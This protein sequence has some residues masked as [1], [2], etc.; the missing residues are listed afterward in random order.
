MKKIMVLALAVLFGTPPLHA[1]N[2]QL[3]ETQWKA[4]EG[5]YQ[6]GIN[7][8]YVR[9]TRLEG[10]KLELRFPATGKRLLL[11]P[12]SELVF[13]RAPSEGEG[14][15][16]INFHRD[17][18]TGEVTAAGVGNDMLWNRV[19][20]YHPIEPKE[21]AH[22][23]ED[24]KPFEGI[25]RRKFGPDHY[26]FIQLKEKANQLVFKQHWDGREFVFLP[27]SALHFF[28]HEAT[29]F[30]LRF[31]KSPDGQITEFVAFDRDHWSKQEL[32]VTAAGMRAYEGKYRS[33]SDP[34]NQ[35]QLIVRD[36]NLVVKQVWD[37]KEIVLTPMTDIYF[38]NETQSYPLQIRLGTDGKVSSI[39]VLSSQEF[40]KVPE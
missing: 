10:D 22:T 13:D 14:P 7:K 8:D 6:N 11:I 15:R 33:K 5:V 24:L 9:F 32:S 16:Q 29:R 35:L 4:V 3:T 31:T 19:K 30:T 12:E 1:Q 39:L 21:M 40:D 18:A 25:Y 20:N 28:T 26:E 27:D 34:D 23:P 17:P 38:Y 37:G 2:V 36:G